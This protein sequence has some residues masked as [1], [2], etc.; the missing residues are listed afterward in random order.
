MNDLFW[1][2]ED[3]ASQRPAPGSLV[4]DEDT[5]TGIETL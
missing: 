4:R 5:E 1:L 3:Q 2:D